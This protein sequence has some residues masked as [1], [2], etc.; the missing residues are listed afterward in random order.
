[1]RGLEEGQQVTAFLH[2]D[3]AAAAPIKELVAR[4]GV[5]KQWNV[6][7]L[8][9]LQP[10]KEALR[11]TFPVSELDQFDAILVSLGSLPAMCYVP[12]LVESLTQTRTPYIL[13]CQFNSAHLPVTPGERVAVRKVMA[14]SAGCIFL[15]QRNLDE[16]RRQFAVE[17]PQGWLL[18]NPVRENSARPL[19]WP[20]MEGGVRWASVARF[21]MLWKGQDILLDILRQPVWRERAWHLTFYGSGPD[22]EDL[23]RL[24]S[25]FQLQDRVSFAG[26]VNGLEEIWRDNHVLVLPSHGEGLPLAALEA[27]MLGRPVVATDVGGNRELIDEGDTG[28]IAEGSTAYSF[29]QALE[30]AWHVREQWPAM[31]QRAHVR[32][33]QM[34]RLDPTQQLLALWKQAGVRS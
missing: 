3:I 20:A 27:M 14:K 32:V 29:H 18:P 19:A 5:V 30:R 7:R 34:A 8:A 2:P 1:M 24:V 6:L 9:R 4:G 10:W 33:M 31:G 23:E 13:F 16:A 11:A 21:E 12:G 26:F 15:S 28:F 17:P 22:R 25:L